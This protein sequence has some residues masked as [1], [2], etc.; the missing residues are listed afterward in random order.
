MDTGTWGYTQKQTSW[1]WSK[2]S[3]IIKQQIQ[4]FS[5]W[6]WNQQRTSSS[7][8]VPT[9]NSRKNGKTEN[10]DNTSMWRCR[11]AQEDVGANWHHWKQWTPIEKNLHG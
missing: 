3:S 8:R 10:T 7:I 2:E 9:K 6:Q 1:Q 4:S 11:G 5:T